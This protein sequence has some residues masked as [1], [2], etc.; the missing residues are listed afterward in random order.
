MI[1]AIIMEHATVGR[2]FFKLCTSTNLMSA[3][4]ATRETARKMYVINL[5]SHK[6]VGKKLMLRNETN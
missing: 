4:G 3:I 5:F 1:R 6:P 2:I